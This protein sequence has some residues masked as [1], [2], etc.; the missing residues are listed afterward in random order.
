MDWQWFLIE[1]LQ[2]LFVGALS[3]L[4][5]M[6]VFNKYFLPKMVA[7]MGT[8]FIKAIQKD[9]EIKPLID[10][11]K[12]LLNRLEPFVK[13]LKSVDLDKLQSDFKPLLET[14]KK[15]DPETIEELLQTLKELAGNFKEKL[16]KPKI[17][18]PD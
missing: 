11:A 14:V 5:S 13:Q 9:P 12:D 16:E 17:P 2:G 6:W 3:F 8:D 15:I 7:N 1:C 4:F 10:K 18:K